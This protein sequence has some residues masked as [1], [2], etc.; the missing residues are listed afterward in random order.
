MFQFYTHVFKEKSNI[1]VRGRDPYGKREQ[2]VIKYKPYLFVPSPKPTKYKN[3][4]GQD[5]AKMDFDSIYEAQQFI[6]KYDDVKNFSIYGYQKFE[7]NWI[8]DYFPNLEFKP[9]QINIGYLDI[10]VL[11]REGFPKPERAEHEITVISIHKNGKTYVFTTK[12]YEA[13]SPSVIVFVCKSEKDL[14]MKF[15]VVWEKL[16]LD[17]ISGWYIDGFDI[18]YIINRLIN[19]FDYETACKLSPWRKLKSRTTTDKYERETTEWTIVG[20]S[21]LDYRTVYMKF[22]TSKKD[23]Y[24]LNNI[25][26]IELKETKIDYSEYES[27][28]ELW[29]NNPEKY[30]DYNIHDTELVVRLEEKLKYL[31]R[32][33]VV[34]YDAKINYEDTLG[35]VLMWEVII[36]NYLM[37][38]NVAMPIVKVSSHKTRIEGAY[39]KPPQIKLFNWSVSFDLTSLYPHIIIGNNISTDT[40]AGKAKTRLSIDQM[41][42]G[43]FK[44]N[45]YIKDN[46]CITG[47]NCLYRNDIEGFLPTIM[48]EQFKQRN[49]Y[50]KKMLDLKKEYAKTKNES[51]K[52]EITKYDNYQ[53]GKKI[54]LN[55][56][57]GATANNYFI[58]YNIDNAEAVTYTGQVVI[59]RAEKM[60]NI[61]MNDLFKTQNVD[62]VIA[63][64]TDSIYLNVEKFVESTGLTDKNEIVDAIDE[65]SK[66]VISKAFED[67]FE[68]LITM[69]NCRKNALEMKREGIFEKALWR[70]KKNYAL[71][72][73][74]NE[75][76]RYNPPQV[77]IVGMES[78]R[79][80]T[81][82][83]CRRKF[84]KAVE[85]LFDSG[86]DALKKLIKDFRAEYF[87]LSLFDIGR[88]IAVNDFSKYLDNSERIYKL[89]APIG[90][91]GAILYNKFIRDNKLDNKYKL[92][93]DGD[94]IK[95]LQLKKVN[96]IGDEVIGAPD[97]NFPAELQIEPYVDKTLMFET[98]FENP[99]K[100]LLRAAGYDTED[101]NTLEAFF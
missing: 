73:W 49:L 101:R 72:I 51:L 31:E 66:N 28:T 27:L 71:K 2:K 90:V 22:A 5:I 81:P 4:A 43:E 92:L 78:V 41:V 62:Y 12:P 97:G 14:L 32:A 50:K 80:S 75:G 84:E 67:I 24:S 44:T 59:R 87:K 1:F 61:F 96:P 54:S 64:D 20:I 95:Y 34:A 98:T 56:A 52:N 46:V 53:Y 17:I 58:F 3:I 37:K 68:E 35:A 13:K 16:D 9:E 65:F 19:L 85:L 55:S 23:S 11:S 39:V 26:Y 76:A 18:P 93:T 42:R 70:A 91:K 89:G 94:K 25:A 15:L 10:E 7:Y 99:A 38:R 47:N 69:M 30:I 77:K 40:F 48:E 83:I 45:E 74:D 60:I 82:E 86:P 21:S 79:S 8:H 88:P 100:T 63:S 36:M 33:I 29:D 6:K 57:Y